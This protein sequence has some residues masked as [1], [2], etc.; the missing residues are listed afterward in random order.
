MSN[1]NQNIEGRKPTLIIRDLC[2]TYQNQAEKLEVLKNVNAEFHAGKLYAI[3]GESGSGKTTLLSLISG[4][5]E[6]QKGEI[7][8]GEK[9]I[10]EIG[11]QNF[12]K[13]YVNVVFQAFNLIKYMT[14]SEN[15]Q[16]ALDFAGKK[17]RAE[18]FLAEV[19]LT[20]DESKRL[21]GKLSGGQQQRV[22]IARALASNK[23]IVVA[24][25]PTGALDE[26]TEAKIIQIFQDLCRKHNKIVILVTHSDRVSCHA[27]AVLELRNGELRRK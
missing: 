8:Y 6:I 2:H 15:V 21:I 11:L 27:D 10:H 9:S 18:K 26:K 16:I 5:D 14:A 19:G 20:N 17:S 4:L 22:A 25:E 7:T 23:P 1:K 3:K 12:R 24:D 13:D